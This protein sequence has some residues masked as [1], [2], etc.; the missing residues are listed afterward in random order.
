MSV[1]RL[2]ILD[3]VRCR[4]TNC[5]IKLKNMQARF[6]TMHNAQNLILAYISEWM[7][8]NVVESLQPLRA[9]NATK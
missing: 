8:A 6:G 5:A 9:E 3:I 4:Q 1:R 7:D 2:D